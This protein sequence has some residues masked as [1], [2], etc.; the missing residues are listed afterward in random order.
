MGAAQGRRNQVDVALAHHLAAVGD[1]LQGPIDRFVVALGRTG[2]GLCR[3][4]FAFAEGLAQVTGEAVVVLPG[5][6]AGL[7]ARAIGEGDGETGAEHGLGAQ[8]VLEAPDGQPVRVEVRS[9]R[10]KAYP[11][12][13]VAAVD[14]TCL[15]ELR[16][17]R[18]T[19][20]ALP[21]AGAAALHFHFQP[22]RQRV[23]HRH[24]DAVQAAGKGVVLAVELA[25]GVQAREDQ[26]NAGEAMFRMHIHRHSAAVIGHLD[27]AIGADDDIDAATE[28]GKHLI[29]A[30]VHHLLNEMVGAGGVGVHA[31]APAHR[32]QPG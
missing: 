26:F 29:D 32:F 31:G 28:A 12:A 24:A 3:H 6:G 20:V 17:G 16:G 30:V 2:E 5:L 1:P 9:V 19:L 21:I 23:H 22:R 27:G 8:Q 25:A 13:G 14:A 18:A 7:A 11:R 4:R 15:L 10:Q